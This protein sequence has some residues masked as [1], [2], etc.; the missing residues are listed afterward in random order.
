METRGPLWALIDVYGNSTAIEFVDIR[1]QLNNSRRIIGSN[2]CENNSPEEVERIIYRMDQMQMQQNEEMT[3]PVLRYQPQHL[4][5]NPLTLHR[6]RGRNVKFGNARNNAYRNDTEFCQGYVF[7]ARP[8]QIGER[9]VVQIM[10]T[11]PMFQ[12]CLGLGLTSCDPGTLQSQDLPDDSNFLLDRPEYWVL[13]RD[14]ARNLNKG[15]EVSFGILPNGEVQISRNG[16]NPLVVIHV[17]QSLKL[18]GFFDI[19]GST[20]RIR[21]MSSPSPVSP[22]RRIISPS[23][24]ESMNTINSQSEIRR[25]SVLQSNSRLC[26]VAPADIQVQP[27]TNGGAVLSVILPPSHANFINQPHPSFVPLSPS[28][29]V[30][31]IPVTPAMSGTGTMISTCSNTYVE[32][33]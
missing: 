20:Q 29:V 13:S 22:I 14:F 21:V 9:I 26:C 25:N 3:L 15:D 10:A 5:F 12:G 32:V 24:T 33:R 1:H 6:T 8:L 4:N 18:W 2:G 23:A 7:T 28:T 16:D 27:S 11:E 19:Y 17:D 30:A 31:P